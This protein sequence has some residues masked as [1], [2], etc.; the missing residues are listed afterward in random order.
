VRVNDAA[1]PRTEL[2]VADARA[3]P[4]A[5][6][7]APRGR[8]FRKYLLLILT[9]VTIAL[10]ASGGISVYFTY[11]ETRAALA[12]LQH[13]KALAAAARIEQY[14]HQIEQQLAYAAL[15]QLDASDPGLR[16]LELLKLLRQTPEITDVAQI[17]GTGREQIVVSRLGMDSIDSGKDRSDEPAFR[18]PKRGRHWYGPVYF[19]KDT[20]PYMKIATR[21]GG[22]KGPVTVADVNLKFIW[23]IVSQIHIGEKGKAYV[24]DGNGFLIADPDIGLVLRKTDLSALPHVRAATASADPSE[25]ALA[26]VD[27][28]GTPILTSFAPIESLRWRVFVEQPV[29]EVYDKLNASILRTV[30]L[31]FAGLALSAL[32]AWALARGMVRPIRTLDEGAQRI[33]G[34]DLEQRIEVRTG[35]ELEALAN[36]FNRMSGRLRESYA[37]LERKVEARTHELQNTLDQQTAISEILRVISSS[38]TDVQPVL[39]A[40]AE[41]AAH[42]CSAPYARVMLIDGDVLRAAAE[43]SAEP[44]F[45]GEPVPVARTSISGRAVTDLATVH[46][47]DI[48][49]IAETEFPGAAANIRRL[50]CR[51]VLA[52]PL[53]RENGAYGAIFL[54]RREPGLFAP[55]Q[56]ALVQTFAA[57][58]AIAIDNVR[59]FNET[60]E[61]LA[62]QTAISEI[63]RVI[64]GSPTDVRPMLNAVTES[65]LKLCDAAESGFLLLEGN[66]LRF[67]A[68]HG[69]MPTFREGELLP[70]TPGLVVGRAVLEGRTFHHPDIVPLLD[71]EYP[72]AR[73]NQERFGF[74]ALL[75]VPLM[76][77]KSAI[78]AFALWRNEPRAFTEKQVAL[79]KTFA[80][81]AAIAIDNVRL[82]NE[83]KEALAQQTAISEILRVISGSPTDVQPVLDIVAERAAHLCAAPMA[84]VLL[85]DG[86]VLRPVAQYSTRSAPLP[87]FTPTPLKRTSISG[88]AAIDRETVHVPDI[89]PLL[90]T[91]FCDS[92]NALA[93]GVRSA[94]GVPLLREGGAYGTILLWRDTVQPFTAEQIALVQTFAA[95]AAIA[96][97]NVRL[98]NQTKE[99][100][101]Q[102]T[103][104]AEILHVISRSPTDVLPVLDAIAERASKLCDAS[105]ASMY[106]IDGDMLRHLASKGPSPDPVSHVDTLPIS[107]DTVTGRA[108]LERR[109][110]QLPDLLS[111]ADE[112]PLSREI[113]RRFGHRTVVVVPLLREDEPF[114][115]ILLRRHE[116]RPF[117]EREISLLH[118][119]GNQAAIALENVRLFNETREALDQQ[120]ASGEVLAAISNSIADTT[121]VFE[122]ILQSCKR[123]FAGRTIGIN[124]VGEDGQIRL[125]AFHGPGR[126]ELEKIWPAPVDDRTGSGRAIRTR[127]IVHFPD[128][129]DR[130][131]VSETTRLACRAIGVRAVIFAPMLWEGNGI[132]AIFVGRDYAGP[133][134]EKDVALLRTFADQAV[135]AIQNARLF[136]ETNQALERQTATAEVLRAISR[137]TFQLQPVLEMLIE[138]ATRMCKAEKGH[139]FI[140]E[141]DVFQFTASHGAPPDFIAWMQLHPVRVGPE[142]AVGRAALTG[143]AVHIED[144]KSDPDYAWAEAR[145]RLGFRTILAV[146]MMREGDP[147]GVIVVWRDEVRPF[148]PRDIQLLASFA[149]QAVIA[150]ENVRLFREIQD[151]SRQLEVANKHKSEFLAN[152][153]HELRTPLNA[154]IGFS[155]VLLERLFGDLND[156]QNEYLNDIHASGRHLLSLINDILDLSKIE[157][158]RM[159]LEHS[160]FD[161]TSALSNALTLVRERAQRHGIALSQSV[162]PDLGE[163][164]ADERKLKQIL[165]NLLS[166]AV[167]FTP[168]GGRIDVTA[169]RADGHAVV[170]VHDTG[171]GIA[172]RDQHTVFEEFRQV[173]HDYTRKQ[174][175]TGL[176]L[177]LTRRFVELHGGRIW[178]ESEPGKGSTFTFTIPLGP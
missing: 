89:V 149:D 120:R 5:E 24:V 3:E 39:E 67:V 161:L 109:T 91:E 94:L 76:R 40:V 143:Q 4:A 53:I 49:P 101:E 75:A 160:C 146:P 166:N 133:F 84:R 175:G 135:I 73:A 64:S 164:V 97:D 127:T 63:L 163:I 172:A 17:D 86:E 141:G 29:A 142:T 92:K 65:A 8:L 105:A 110:I 136:N 104:V 32:G 170:A 13:E 2:I 107:R 60:K 106:L 37:G 56:V 28:S 95:Q 11:Q 23:D 125:G 80:D 159:E 158:G 162:D 46:L 112:F 18:E 117:S 174:E 129:E 42:L 87:P 122:K 22:D 71:T 121:P 124:L 134:A 10:L 82:F 103:A 35:D 130:A 144:A 59:L 114:G 90:E 34:G 48:A 171:I 155:E 79:V 21:S 168:D 70:L 140:R 51:A 38:P 128:I 123:L 156:K 27:A 78:G 19:R 62:Q 41:R 9:L 77:E 147:I 169:R 52:V 151:K 99:G 98:F 16:R 6:R 132:G 7:T 139:V 137:T 153:S 93:Q 138:N 44:T 102:Q 57:Q 113:A 31:L 126:E 54:F 61:A 148:A 118:T 68:G 14:I 145:D 100:L 119:F 85:V 69:S 15:P 12:S 165:L 20:E 36:Q 58:A 178:L 115:A 108:V 74:R 50:G 152:M 30:L 72:A 55:D 96:I 150:I 45:R 157:A 66:H 25:S 33:G 173:G 1:R 47:A 176:G 116:V 111:E 43:Y 81:Q 167:K 154:I 83:T 88:R 26:S 177:A 131:R